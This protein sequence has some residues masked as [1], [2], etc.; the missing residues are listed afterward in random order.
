MPETSEP[1]LLHPDSFPTSSPRARH[2]RDLSCE[3]AAM[4]DGIA[5]ANAVTAVG[6]G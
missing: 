1:I 3:A 4:R 5:S 6:R 2:P